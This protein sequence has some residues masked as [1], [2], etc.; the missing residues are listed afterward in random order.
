MTKR[1][2]DLLSIGEVAERSGFATSAIR[3]YEEQ[4]LVRAERNQGNQR[5]F[6]RHALRRLAFIR[7]AQRVGLSLDEIAAALATLPSDRAPTRHSWA[8]LSTTWRARLD[9]QIAALEALR[10]DLSSCIGCGCLSLASCRLSN[11]QDAVAIRGDGP[12]Y[13]LG[14]DPDGFAAS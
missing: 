13:L 11:P 9:E 3:F 14:D 12:R 4:G 6:P 1:R 5:M 7:A 10:D 8:R 2:D